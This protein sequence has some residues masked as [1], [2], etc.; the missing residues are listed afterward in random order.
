MWNPRLNVSRSPIPESSCGALF[1][2]AFCVLLASGCGKKN[3]GPDLPA[4]D[5]SEVP[6][7]LTVVRAD[8]L[9]KAPDAA[10][11]EA[12]WQDFYARHPAFTVFYRDWLLQIPPDS[13]PDDGNPIPAIYR[14][15]VAPPTMRALN[16]TLH[17]R[18]G[19]L[20]QPI[21]ELDLAYRY[22]RYYY[23]LDTLPP[24]YLYSGIFGQPVDLTPDFA[25]VALTMFLG[26]DFS[27]YRSFPSENLPRF[28]YH[29]LEP[30]YI[31]V[32]VMDAVARTRWVPEFPENSVLQHMI[33]EGKLLAYLDRVMPAVPDSLKIGYTALQQEW[34]EVNQAEAWALLVG[35]SLL[36]STRTQ[37]IA[38]IVGE[39]PHTKGMSLES[40]SRVG[41]WLGWQIVRAYLE[42]YPNTTL[43][44]LFAM[45]DAR[46]LLELSRWKAETP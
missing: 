40:P 43:D 7:S 5:I 20:Q 27:G 22:H 26:R 35:E 16:D 42:R 45:Q 32:R 31:P 46:Q 13:L 17:D 6:S 23:P 11:F 37:D 1:L 30:A 14:T 15:F 2:L 39:G 29:R 3:S 10:S 28:L 24:V 21:A 8:A 33:Y 25:A 36:F 38:R 19:A 34:V 9:L 44:E 12:A 4:P 41:V 18:L